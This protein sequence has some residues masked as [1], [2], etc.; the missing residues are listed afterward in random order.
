MV[1]YLI[2]TYIHK[3]LILF[4]LFINSGHLFELHSPAAKGGL[5]LTVCNNWM[6]CV[7]HRERCVTGANFIH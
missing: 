3:V 2:H 5:Q 7:K 4:S 6:E 1:T